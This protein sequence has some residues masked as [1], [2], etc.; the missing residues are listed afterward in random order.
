MMTQVVGQMSMHDSDDTSYSHNAALMLGHRLRRRLSLKSALGGR[1]VLG[2][3]CNQSLWRPRSLS[4]VMRV[5]AAVVHDQMTFHMQTIQNKCDH[6]YLRG[7]SLALPAG[8]FLFRGILFREIYHV[9][10]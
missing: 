1:V 10:N 4:S 7:R 6:T 3:K 8:I 2:W 5:G 9:A